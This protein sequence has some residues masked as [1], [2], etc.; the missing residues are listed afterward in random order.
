MRGQ[1]VYPYAS[2]LCYTEVLMNK[3]VAGPHEDITCRIIGAA[4]AVHRRLGPGH[5]EEVYQRAL[6]AEFEEVGLS[7]EAQKCLEVYKGQV[8]QAVPT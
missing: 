4:M 5:K 6:E 7:F 8:W 3:K 2:V 1:S